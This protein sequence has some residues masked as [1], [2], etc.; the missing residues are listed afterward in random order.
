MAH[1]H[2][3]SSFRP[4]GCL[5]AAL[6]AGFMSLSGGAQASNEAPDEAP[7]AAAGAEFKQQLWLDSG[8]WS[9][10]TRSN[11]NSGKPYREHNAGL[12]LE[13]HFK[14]QWQVNAGHYRN[15]LD[16]PSNYLQLGWMPLSWSPA[17]DLKLE[18]GGSVGVVNGYPGI[19]DRGYFPSL[20]PVATVEWRRV[21]INFVYIPSIGRI[22][23]AYAAQLKFLVF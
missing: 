2:V 12:G 5:G 11:T 17:G 4:L 16:E 3:S 20:V 6:T 1:P 7:H 23:G 10:H 18:L 15:S 19:A 14:P 21:G 13:W 9:H 8:F 22:H